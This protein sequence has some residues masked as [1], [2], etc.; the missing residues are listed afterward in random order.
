MIFYA[1][2]CSIH[3][4]EYVLSEIESKHCIRVLRKQ[5]GSNIELINGKGGHFICE[6][7]DPHVKRCKVKI[8]EKKQ[9]EV[10]QENIHIAMAIPKSSE[11][12]EWFL[13][14]ATELGINTLSLINCRNSER[15]K[16]NEK[17]LEKI[18][19]SAMKQSKRFHLP[20][21]NN[22]ITFEAYLKLYPKGFIG[23]CYSGEK[24][25]A[26]EIK[27]IAPFLIGPEGD[28][29]KDEVKAARDSGYT[30]I[31]L[32]RQRLRTETAALTS[33]FYLAGV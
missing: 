21:I 18:A 29:T 5:H 9:H 19:I 26:K 6:I 16:I 31:E 23:H 10:S 13:E 17:R 27:T 24:I 11:R 32:S 14:K 2:D 4:E 22:P 3:E 1:P 12:L 33:V 30:E 8:K 7:I 28:F 20:K 25:N 15:T